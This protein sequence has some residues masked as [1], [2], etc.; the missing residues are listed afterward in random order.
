M[1][2]KEKAKK[3]VIDFLN[4]VWN[5]VDHYRYPFLRETIANVGM[6]DDFEA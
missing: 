3:K 6:M 4:I 5:S 1:I 2:Y